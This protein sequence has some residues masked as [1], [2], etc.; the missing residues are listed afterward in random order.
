VGFTDKNENFDFGVVGTTRLDA[1][2]DVEVIPITL[3]Y[4]YENS[5]TNKLN[6][7][8]GAGAGIA[9]YDAEISVTES[10]SQDDILF[11]V[12]VFAGLVYNVIESF[13][14]FGGAKYIFMDVFRFLHRTNSSL[15]NLI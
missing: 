12:H 8:I 9:L 4:K 1:D 13:E 3:N 15:M 5:L 14:I 10:A 2:I 6:W 7:Y 11:Y